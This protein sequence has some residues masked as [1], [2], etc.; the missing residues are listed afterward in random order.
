MKKILQ[1]EEKILRRIAR[2]VPVSDIKTTKI[3]KMLE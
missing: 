1:K 3:K 2:E